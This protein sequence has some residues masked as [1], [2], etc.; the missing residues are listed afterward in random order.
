MEKVKFRRTSRIVG[1]IDVGLSVT[2]LVSTVVILLALDH[3][4]W[5]EKDP[6]PVRQYAQS[7]GKWSK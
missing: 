5:F 1:C 4:N 2:A 6:P 7:N 3:P